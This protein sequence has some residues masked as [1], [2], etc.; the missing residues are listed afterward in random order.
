MMHLTH[1]PR[2]RFSRRL[3]ALLLAL[4]LELT[5]LPATGWA[6]PI[7]M[8]RTATL[9]SLP[10]GAPLSNQTS[11]TDF[12]VSVLDI[13]AV[14]ADRQSAYQDAVATEAFLATACTQP[15]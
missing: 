6:A 12:G 8:E 5:S 10:I 7:S 3:A 9:S 4:G 1:R 15:C 13:F 11:S 14:V 2:G